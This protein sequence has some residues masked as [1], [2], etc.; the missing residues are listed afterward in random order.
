MKEKNTDWR[1]F[2]Q[3][4]RSLNWPKAVTAAALILA[5]ASTGIGLIIPL[6]MQDLVDTLS[7]ES[8]D[9][10]LFGLLLLVFFL[11]AVAGGVS[12][13][14]LT[15]IG[16]TIVADLRTRLWRHVLRLPV[17]YFDQHE[18]GQTMSRITQDTTTLK[19][20]VTDHAVTFITGLLSVVG[21]VAILL[22]IDWKMTL[23]M[24]VSVPVSMAILI[25][26]G[27]MMHR[28]A[29]ATQD[30]MAAFSGLL[31]RVLAEIRLVKAYRAEQPESENGQAAIRRLFGFGLKEAKIQAV[32]S[33]AMTFIMMGILVVILGYGGVQV[34]NGN[35]TAGEL[36]AV[37]F[38]LFQIVVPFARMAAFFTAFQKAVGATERIKSILS[39]K[40]EQDSGTSSPKAADVTF[41]KVSF[42]YES[43]KPILKDVS[44]QAEAGTVTAFV[45]PSGGG[46]TTIFSLIERF[47][48]PVAGRITSSGISITDFTLRE[49]RGKI[50][51]VS[52]ES[53]LMSGSIRDNISYGI[54][55]DVPEE[56]LIIAARDANALEFIEQLTDGF[57]TLVGERGIKL[58]GGQRQRI[59]IAR[60]LLHDPEI[61]LL[62]EATSSLDSSSE[63]L[64]QDAL[65]RLMRGRTTLVIAHRLSTV[66]NASRL[67]FL[68]RGQ[69]TG[70]GTH[71][72]LLASHELYR[73]FAAGQ[74]LE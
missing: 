21:A 16:E 10:R 9:W 7:V 13:Y 74:G 15:Y 43:G 35:L 22:F 6:V 73:T 8:M 48:L 65:Q 54:A 25:P 33:P 29:R 53:P 58:S 42:S 12:Y 51:Y 19:Q 72:E 52:Q 67:V 62:D 32:V 64:V 3:L 5:I 41:D 47:Y 45:G 60:A 34:A 63:I 4:L 18:T 57:D 17:P 26:L 71:A 44:F 11:Q 50:G 1:Q 55:G 37:L 24:L 14:M 66:I 39:S 23:I 49:W 68:E 20:L 61:L 70:T 69:V 46:K 56:R 28:V 2:L 59:A 38:Y 31:G 30:E 36:V 40:T 27:R